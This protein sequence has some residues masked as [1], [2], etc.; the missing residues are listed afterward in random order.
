MNNI[1]TNEDSYILHNNTEYKEYSVKYAIHQI[2]LQRLQS[3]QYY[4]D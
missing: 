3:I 4:N 2:L 1:H